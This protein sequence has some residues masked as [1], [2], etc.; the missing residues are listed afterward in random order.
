M[1][2]SVLN[3]SRDFTSLNWRSLYPK[4]AFV[5]L[6]GY[7]VF[8]L[9]R[10]TW[11]PIYLSIL[12]L[13]SF[14]GDWI[15]LR[16]Q[17]QWCHQALLKC[18]TSIDNTV[19]ALSSFEINISERISQCIVSHLTHDRY[20]SVTWTEV[21]LIRYWS[22][23]LGY[24]YRKRDSWEDRGKQRSQSHLFQNKTKQKWISMRMMLTPMFLIKQTS[25]KTDTKQSEQ[26]HKQNKTQ[27]KQ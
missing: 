7:P 24:R 16:L 12:T 21:S 2:K 15:Y 9:L 25:E 17:G 20:C 26:K 13:T 3:D 1:I 18:Q 8:R 27:F 10:N 23:P 5:P 14:R 6:L 4:I 19:W 11:I 22:K